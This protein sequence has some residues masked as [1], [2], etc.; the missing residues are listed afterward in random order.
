[1]N[2]QQ[3]IRDAVIKLEVKMEAMSDA[4]SVMADAVTKLSDMRFEM[5]EMRK[6]VSLLVSKIDKHEKAILDLQN[7]QNQLEK[8][9]DKNTYVIGKIELFWSA[10]I[11]GGAA[12]LWWLLKV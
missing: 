4:M 9:Q 5:V 3:Q 2:E 11:T 12:F 10:L 6:D 8:A 1:M 7:R